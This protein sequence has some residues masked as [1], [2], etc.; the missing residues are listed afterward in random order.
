MFTATGELPQIV[1]ATW[2][3]V[4]SY[5]SDED[6]EYTRA[7]TTDFDYYSGPN[8]IEVYIAIQ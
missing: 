2:T 3:K 6:S 4:W 5:F 8:E 1:I 7:Y